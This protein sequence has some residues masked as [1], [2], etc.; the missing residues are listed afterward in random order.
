MSPLLSSSAS[1]LLRVALS[2]IFFFLASPAP[3]DASYS[4]YEGKIN[5]H[6]QEG[7]NALASGDLPAAIEQY[8]ACLKLDPNQQYCNINYASALVDSVEKE[9]DEAAKEER[10]AKAISV[11]RHVLSLHPRD[12]DAAFNLALLLQDSS[13]S[14]EI[15]KEAADL[16][17]IAVEVSDAEEDT[18]WDALANM[19]AAKK[20]IG[21]FMGPYGA[22][23]SYER[24]I[25]VIEGMVNERNE[26]IDQ[27]VNRDSSGEVEYD[28]EGFQRAQRQVNSMN[29][30][31][32][33]LYYGYGTVLSELSPSDCLRLV[34]EESL[35]IDANEGNT[36]DAAKAVCESNALNAM[37]LAVDLDGNNVVAMHMLSA[38]TGGEDGGDFQGQGRASNEF[39]SALFDDF[40]DTFD[41]KLGALGYKVPQLIG[42]AAFDL[43]SMLSEDS[44]RS[45]LD[46][47][48]GTGLAGRFLRPLIDGPL[49]GVDLSKKMLDLAAECTILKGCGLKEEETTGAD[50]GEDERAQTPLYNNL[51]S[52]DLETATLDELASGEQIDGFDLIVAADVLVYFGDIQKLLLNFAKLSNENNPNGSFLIFSCERIDDEDAPP[53][54]WA[55]QSSGRYAHSKAYVSKVADEAGYDIIGYEHIVPRMEK[56]EEVKGHLF[57]LATGG[58]AIEEESMFDEDGEHF[59]EDGMEYEYV[60]NEWI[61]EDNEL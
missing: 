61:E 16:Y 10:T 4:A 3:I 36:E 18:R 40:A 52:A 58:H 15:T 28:E 29:V 20:E 53:S 17:Q 39:V 13:R 51:V 42:E 31:L 26:Y 60:V 8:E 30:Y 56:G 55:L 1:R 44:F 38:M 49:V 54:G 57:V 35:L 43:L 37:R 6:L 11:L 34:R 45:A 22:R 19:A 32:S 47:G 5:N 48:C 24:A 59:D 7:N 12:G 33:K 14:E 23:R 27:M 25:V 9:K 21:E 2:A 46:A 41:E 50:S